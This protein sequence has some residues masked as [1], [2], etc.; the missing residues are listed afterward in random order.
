MASQGLSNRQLQ[1]HW[2]TIQD[3]ACKLRLEGCGVL[4]L[5]SYMLYTVSIASIALNDSIWFTAA[6]VAR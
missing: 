2:D 5:L 3:R 4:M 6:K 1:L